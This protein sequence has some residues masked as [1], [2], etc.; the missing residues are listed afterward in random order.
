M[1]FK[2]IKKKKK[3]KKQDWRD[4]SGAKSTDASS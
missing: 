3:K 4:N 2:V 1:N